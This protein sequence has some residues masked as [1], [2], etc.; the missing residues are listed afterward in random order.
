EVTVFP[1]TVSAAAIAAG[2]LLFVPNVGATTAALV[3]Q[4]RDDGGVL[5]GGVDLDGSANTLTFNVSVANAAAVAVDDADSTDENLVAT[6]NV[7]GANPTTADSDADGPALQVAAVNS[8]GALVGNA[9]TLPS[10]ALLTLNGDGSY[11][12]DP[13][14]RFNYLITAAKALATGAVNVSA[15]DSFTYTLLNGNTATVTITING[16]ESADDQLRGNGGGNAITGLTGIDFIDLS[17]GG[18][19]SAAGGDGDDAIYLGGAMTSADVITGGIGDD[20]LG[21]Q[22]D[23]SGGLTLNPGVIIDT[24]VLL[25]GAD[26][27]FGDPG[28]SFYSYFITTVNGNVAPG[29]TLII[30][31]NQLRVGE[32]FIFDGSAETDG[33]FILYTGG[34]DNDLTGGDQSDGFFFGSGTFDAND[35]VDGGPGPDDQVAF[36]GNYVIVFTATQLIEIETIVPLSG[37]DRGQPFFS[38]SLTM[39]DGN[40]L[41]GEQMTVNAAQLKPAESL[42]LDGSA[43]T[44]GSFRLIGGYG[45]DILIGSQ[46]NDLIF[47]NPGDDL[48]T[49]EGGADTLTGMAGADTFIYND[50]SESTG[51]ARDIIADFA[52]GDL[53]DLSA[54]DADETSGVDAFTFIGSAAFSSTAG[55]LRAFEDVGQPGRWFVEG[56]VDGDGLADFALQVT[57]ADFDP[58]TASDFI[59]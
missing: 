39:N 22:G 40:V 30:N 3:F 4:V 18:D 13:N 23:Y 48:I 56:D 28:T 59:L 51:L 35:V 54:I 2:Q 50:K 21:L 46:G 1:Q 14:G 32:N 53:I 45:N 10:G 17:Q 26:T 27:R 38:Y 44:D 36:F 11:S 55:Q 37:P 52:V 57:V 43:E 24:I 6:G 15:T 12:Y 34:G 42:T 47:G 16:V 8:S 20:Q 7:L 49:G 29:G 5:N 58:V 25:D 31:S 33:G 9:I 19:D 41:A